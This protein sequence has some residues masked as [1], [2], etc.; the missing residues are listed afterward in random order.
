MT[1]EINDVNEKNADFWN[2]L[3]GTQLAQHLGITEHTP[4]SL[5]KF[6][7]FYFDFYPYLTNYIKEEYIKNKKVLE[8]GLGYGTLSRYLM[9]NGAKYYGLDIAEN[10]VNM[11]RLSAEYLGVQSEAHVGSII[12]CPFPDNFFDTV[13]SIGCF[14]H[15]GNFKACIDE[16]FRIL[17]PNGVAIIM[18]YNQYSLRQW[19]TW[20]LLTMKALFKDNFSIS[21]TKAGNKNQ[22]YSYDKNTKDDAAPFT[23]FFSKKSIKYYFRNM[24]DLQIN[25]E[26]FDD[27]FA[28]RIWKLKIYSFKE[29]NKYL[30]SFWS[31]LMGLD[32]YI[33]AKK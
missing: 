28:I 29:R 9:K 17:K 12:N 20:P 18:V 5:E 4:A 25:R 10:P 30:N 3:C 24:R 32:L 33:Y 11:S 14:H 7:N 26:N 21:K 19:V 23:E 27:K 13:I 15:T 1:I 16:T 31:K 2:E 6:D 8:V 22:N